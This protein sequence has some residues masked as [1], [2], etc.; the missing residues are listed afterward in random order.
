MSV[1]YIKEDR[2]S[3][4]VRPGVDTNFVTSHVF[5][6]EHAGSFNNTGT[7]NKEGYV[8]ILFLQFIEE[9]PGVSF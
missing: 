3:Y 4:T 9:S 8:N 6:N 2:V 1:A 5:L 7:D